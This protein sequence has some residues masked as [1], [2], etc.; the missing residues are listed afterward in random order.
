MVAKLFIHHHLCRLT[1]LSTCLD[2]VKRCCLLYKDLVSFKYIFQP[3]GTLLS[4]HLPAQP[5]PELLQ[6]GAGKRFDGVSLSYPRVLILRLPFGRRSFTGRS[7]RPS[8]AF[9]PLTLGW[10][11]TRRSRFLSSCSRP[12]S[13]RC[14]YKPQSIKSKH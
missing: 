11:S 9:P 7:W 12:R 1:C 13:S 3:I 5:L 4:K 8:A 10:F 14:K 2:L 6:V